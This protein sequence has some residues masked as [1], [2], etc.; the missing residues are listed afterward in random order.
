MSAMIEPDATARQRRTGDEN[1]LC[2]VSN[3]MKS[4]LLDSTPGG[5]KIP[6]I[7]DSKGQARVAARRTKTPATTLEPQPAGAADTERHS[8]GVQSIGRAFAILEQIARARQGIRL[9]ELSKRVGLHNSTTFHL[10][11]TMVSLGYIRQ[12]PE[13]K[14]YRIGRPLFTLAASALDDFLHCGEVRDGVRG[15]GGDVPR[16]RPPALRSRAR[17][18]P[19]PRM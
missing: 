17:R 2:P 16:V 7:Q 10:V 18:L 13:D 5:I 3:N 14:S 15:D 19:E 9:A 4:S 8:G 6:V 11:R 1:W 12:M